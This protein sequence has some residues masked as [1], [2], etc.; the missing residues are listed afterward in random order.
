MS[1][2]SDDFESALAS[3]EAIVQRLDSG[4]AQESQHIERAALPQVTFDPA[5]LD[6]TGL[7]DSIE[8]P[9][10]EG[11]RNLL[12]RYSAHQS[13]KN[14]LSRLE[15]A[16]WLAA[17]DRALGATVGSKVLLRGSELG[18]FALQALEHGASY[19]LA[20][21]QFALD[22]RISSGIVQKHLLMQWHALHGST[23]P[24]WSEDERRR[25]FESFA[26]KVDIVP[27]ESERLDAAQC[28][29]FVFPN[30][31]HS[32]LG[33]GIVRAIQQH[34]AR[35]LAAH[36]RIL[37]AR[38]KVFA[39][40]IEWT[41]AS[42]PFRLQAMN[43]LR[44]SMYPQALE[45]PAECWR[46]VTEP[47][48]VG[49]IDFENFAE[50]TW[51]VRLPVLAAGTFDA[52][53]Y[54]FDL[55]LGA[56]EISNAPGSAFQSIRPAIQHADS[57]QVAVGESLPLRV[58]VLETRLHFQTEPPV[59]QIRSHGLPSWYIPMLL[60]K[61]R[62]DG[63]RAALER[64]VGTAP[65]QIVLDIGAGS[66]LLSLMAAQAG[67]AR[68][69]GCEVNSAIAGVGK[70]II[71]ANGVDDRV[72][73]INKD[74]RN[75]TVPEDCSERADLAVFE[76]FDCS[77]IGE[78][79]LHF[80]AYAR[81]HLLKQNARYLPMSAR[82]RAMIIEYRLDRIWSLDVNLLNPYRFSS[83]FINVDADKLGYRALTDPIDVYSF[84]F[85][86]ATPAPAEKEL[87]VPAIERGC[88]GA[89]LFWFDLQ[90]DEAVCLSNAPGAGSG[91]HWKQGLQFLPEVQV[92]PAMPLPLIARHDGSSLTFRWK[93][94]DLPKQ[95]LSRLPRFDL[96]SLAAISEL[97]QQTRGLL[98]HCAQNADEYAKV[99]EL[100]KRFAVDP[101]AHEL[102]PIIAQ[103][104][105]ATFF[106]G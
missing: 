3:G 68:V 71:R 67:A 52:I 85:A 73:L 87:R 89:V 53:V 45:L 51:E 30:I 74:C 79:V 14:T 69:I 28:D 86:D 56:A 37:P 13:V 20:V 35:G 19:A 57:V 58:R 47:V 21:E 103:R 7:P 24:S 55:Q 33:T 98:Q 102:D 41:Y 39:V 2:Y 78:G 32:L 25:S 9:M 61:G 65:D 15:D 38:A 81:A 54:W 104:F 95:A 64:A 42:A 5:L 36:A 8:K 1:D 16:A 72:A 96:R 66:G 84:D 12:R 27:P 90:L 100:A 88:A 76:L 29:Y 10:I 18:T 46:A 17:W 105:A 82:I 44:W 34:R 11:L 63:Y 23:I 75:V 93:Q 48:C 83:A 97:E 43:R 4:A 91:L 49:E 92:E 60:D 77:L 31:D 99:A 62:N 40:G 22:G 59:R 80:L 94:D 6:E 106:G 70:E 50:A 26:S 101:A